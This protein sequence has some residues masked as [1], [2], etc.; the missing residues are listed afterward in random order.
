M[1]NAQDRMASLGVA[2]GLFRAYASILFAEK[3]WI[4]ALFLLA[5]FWFPNAGA[6]GLLAALVAIVTARL[7][8]FIN[9]ESGLHVYNS[10][11]VGLSLGAYYQLDIY[12]AVLVVLGAVLAVFFTVAMADLL[13]RMEHL[14]ALSLPFV[15]VAL[16][17]TLA[18]HSYGTLSRYLLPVAPHDILLGP[19]PDQ[20]FTALGS[21]FFIPHPL[22]G[23][24]MF[25]G[26]LLTSRYLAL[27]AIAGFAAGYA[28]YAFLSGSPHPD[29]VA[30][31]GFN[32]ILVAIALGGIFTVPGRQSFAL[33]MIGAVLAALVTA[34][35]ETFMLVYGLPVMALPFLLTTMILLIALQKRPASQGL[36]LLLESPALPE[37]S[38]E[39]SRLAVVRSGEFGSVPVL[40][41]FYGCW[42]V[43]QGFD[44]QHT[45]QP[46]WQ[47][48]LDFYITEDNKSFRGDGLNAVDYYCFG[49]PVVSPVEGYVVKSQDGLADNSPGKVDME[50][51]WGNHLLIRM[52]NGLYLL[53]AHLKQASIE[54][55]P[56]DFIHAGQ[57]LAL[58][59]S[60]GRSPQPHLHMHV[61]WGEALG[62]ATHPFHMATILLQRKDELQHRFC[63]HARP[64]EASSI[65]S[66]RIDQALATSLQMTVGRQFHY[67]VDVGGKV[68]QAVFTVTLTL[69]GQLRLTSDSGASAALEYQDN[70]LALHDRQ[71]GRDLLLDAW[72]LALGLT[73]FCQGEPTWQDQP[74]LSLFPMRAAQRLRTNMLRPMGGGMHSDYSRH[75]TGERWI[76][77]ASHSVAS[78]DCMATTEAVIQPHLG[79]TGLTLKSNAMQLE[80]RLLKIAQHADEGIPQWNIEISTEQELT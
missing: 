41:P 42:M 20:F 27:L 7:L 66:P 76:Q 61:Q 57:S 23:L 18:A 56:G 6:S 64:A 72:M 9:L 63:L 31:N 54:V 33:A 70:L 1:N 4:G 10:L 3:P 43:Y 74:A 14:P 12:L 52:H 73:P 50:N 45:H 8:A 47:H 17:T 30:W 71:G 26:L 39:R 48:A 13:W 65:I 46:P 62:S 59:G 49:L 79:C 55:R 40:A 24:L 35:T 53:L 29:L 2:N 67:Q 32:F 58:C 22:P 28:T 36:Q 16:T 19:W 68:T 78:A 25:I 37:K 60:S 75:W 11:L 44:G 80:A 38:Y 51:N 21:A 34:A 69:A 15:I 5:T 77:S